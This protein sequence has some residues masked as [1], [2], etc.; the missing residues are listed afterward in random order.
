IENRLEM[1]LK[2][3]Y[4]ERNIVEYEVSDDDK[5][6]ANQALKLAL[7]QSPE[8][9]IH[10]EIRDEDANIYVRACTRGHRGSMTTVHA[11]HL[12]DV[13]DV[14]VDMCMLDKRSMDTE[15]LL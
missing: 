1:M 10:A 2:R 14:I 9:I 4:P 3:D 12:E 8:R 11:N 15:R 6:N 7:R 5:H 13:P